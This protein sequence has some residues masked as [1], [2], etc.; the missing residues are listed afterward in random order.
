MTGTPHRG[1]TDVAWDHFK[2]T[3]VIIPGYQNV[4]AERL[5][6][7]NGEKATGLKSC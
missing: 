3:G 1:H 6:D 2:R 4:I 7:S 5:A